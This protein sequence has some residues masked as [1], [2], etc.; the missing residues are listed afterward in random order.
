MNDSQ[1]GNYDANYYKYYCGMEYGHNQEWEKIFSNQAERIVSEIAP[2]KTLDIGCAIGLLVEA[3]RDRGVAAYG[4]DIS[5]YAIS[6]VREDIQPFCKVQSA[7]KPLN[8]KYDLITCIEVLEHLNHKEITLAIQRMCEA[9][10]DILFSSTP[11]DYNEK[12]HISVHPVEF[13]VEQFAYQGFYHDIQ[14]DCTYIAVQTM[15]FRRGEKDRIELIRS[16]EKALFQKHQEVFAV[17]HQ[18]QLS[19]ENVQIYKEA[20]QKH[21]DIINQD[22]NPRIQALTKELTENRQSTDALINKTEQEANALINKTKQEA[23]ALIN[24]TKQETSV[25]INKIKQDIE[26]EAENRIRP[27]LLKEIEQRKYFEEKYYLNKDEHEALQ[28]CRIELNQAVSSLELLQ[29]SE[30]SFDQLNFHGGLRA[31]LR[32]Y[33]ARKKETKKLLSMNRAYWKAVFDPVYYAKHN[34]D[35]AQAFGLDEDKLLRHFICDGMDEGRYANEEFHL[36]IYMRC[37]PDVVKKWGYNRRGYYL[38]YIADGKK[39]GRRTL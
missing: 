1:Q 6:N 35:V 23:S 30:P 10:D 3:L 24:K 18:L 33:I 37:N 9:T 5:E 11:F 12:T 36:D 28:L 14:Y 29:I 32:A 13:W 26:S 21:V 20:Y 34:A 16:Y 2:K 4:I 19:D 38:H 27:I 7:L 22:L 8:D 25:L 15:R 39:E 31:L 17:R